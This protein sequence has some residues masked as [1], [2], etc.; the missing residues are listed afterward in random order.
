MSSVSKHSKHLSD[1]SDDEDHDSISSAPGVT[2]R[3]G[4]QGTSDESPLP[5]TPPTINL[6]DSSV[7][8]IQKHLAS[9]PRTKELI[10]FL[11]NL[12][13]QMTEDKLPADTKSV[14]SSPKSKKRSSASKKR[15]P[16]TKLEPALD[17]VGTPITIL[18]PP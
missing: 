7:E 14:K 5:T 2:K 15:P 3:R 4:N 16:A 17:D 8:S 1:F 9:L 10:V 13:G 18:M 12:V 6:P 11:S